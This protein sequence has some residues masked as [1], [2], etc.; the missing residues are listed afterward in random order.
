MTHKRG[1]RNP[2]QKKMLAEMTR[3]TRSGGVV[4]L[5][6]HGFDFYNKA[7]EAYIRAI[8]KRYLLGYHIELG[9]RK[10]KEISQMLAQ[11]G[12][13][14]IQTRRLKYQDNFKTG[15]EAYDF[16]ACTSESWWFAKFP[17]EKIAGEAKKAVDYFER[18]AVTKI[19]EDII[20]AHALKP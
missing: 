13:E 12:L 10:E 11:T 20:L 7:I 1:P 9:P 6:T 4:A 5:A 16:F 19:T 8:S 3:V 15:T 2:D 14:D 18:K 17:P